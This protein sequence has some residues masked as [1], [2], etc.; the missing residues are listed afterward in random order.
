MTSLRDID[1][2]KNVIARILS[3]D[4]T[5]DGDVSRNVAV[6]DVRP[7]IVDRIIPQCKPRTNAHRET[8]RGCHIYNG[9]A[10]EVKAMLSEKPIKIPIIAKIRQN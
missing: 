10:C 1:K 4:Q 5:A 2:C 3:L 7:R 8:D 9:R 6:V